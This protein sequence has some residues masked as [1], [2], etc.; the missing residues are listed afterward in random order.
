MRTSRRPGGCIYV[1]VSR[2]RVPPLKRPR[3]VGELCTGVQRSS[4]E[5]ALLARNWPAKLH[6]SHSR[7]QR[8]QSKAV[9]PLSLPAACAGPRLA[10]RID[11][12]PE[13]RYGGRPARPPAASRIY[14]W[15]LKPSPYDGICP[16][17]PPWPMCSLRST[18]RGEAGA[19]SL[20][21][22]WSPP[23]PPP[24]L[25]VAGASRDGGEGTPATAGRPLAR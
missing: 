2:A 8:H 10:S 20:Y 17:R 12:V 1:L 16:T 15:A 6:A 13:G 22:L 14:H 23:G 7:H 9:N 18:K 24:Q 25:V 19:A 3:E 5:Q 21:S 11:F 4:G